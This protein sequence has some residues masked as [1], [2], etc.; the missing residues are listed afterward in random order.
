MA[1]HERVEQW[2]HAAI[3]RRRSVLDLTG[4][5]LAREPG[6][7]R[8]RIA[9]VLRGHR[10]D[11][12]DGIRDVDDDGRG[13]HQ[14]AEFV[15]HDRRE[16]VRAI[17]GTRRVPLRAARTCSDFR[18]EAR[19]VNTKLQPSDTGAVGE[20]REQHDSGERVAIHRQRHRY[21]RKRSG[22]IDGRQRTQASESDNGAEQEGTTIPEGT[23]RPRHDVTTSPE[24]SLDPNSS[25][26]S[27]DGCQ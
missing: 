10:R 18:S 4:A 27:T 8:R 26:A 15:A 24:C 11:L 14:V 7:R 20:C 22:G 16:R 21:A 1:R 17:K 25:R 3:A 19:A 12:R 13:W 9:D 5:R 2:R 23:D 6:D